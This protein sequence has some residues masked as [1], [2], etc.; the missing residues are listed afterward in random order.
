[1]K[2]T[3]NLD[4]QRLYDMLCNAMYADRNFIIPSSEWKK[5]NEFWNSDDNKDG[6]V[7]TPTPCAEWKIWTYIKAADDHVVEFLDTYD[8][9]KCR[10]TWK[11]VQNGTSAM[12]NEYDWHFMDILLENDDAVTA[13]VW[14]QCV[15]LGEVV[16]G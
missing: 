5:V 12:A 9:A 6:R 16:Y 8:E 11:R 4:D 3:F 13:D 14:F 15:L 10:L 2:V 7:G 1:M